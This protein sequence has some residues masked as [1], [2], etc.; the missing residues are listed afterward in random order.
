MRPFPSLPP[1]RLTVPTLLF[2]RLVIANA[3][4]LSRLNDEICHGFKQWC[5]QQKTHWSTAAKNFSG[6]EII[7][8]GPSPLSLFRRVKGCPVGKDDMPGLQRSVKLWVVKTVWRCSFEYIY[9]LRFWVPPKR[10]IKQRDC[11]WHCLQRL[12]SRGGLGAWWHLEWP[13]RRETMPG[14]CPAMPCQCPEPH[15]ASQALVCK[16]WH[17][18]CLLTNP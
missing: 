4:N 16:P 11:V 15:I 7:H 17:S 14:A 2:H 5:A 1:P 3:I 8:P 9:V 13:L 12:S 18:L 6:D 10:K